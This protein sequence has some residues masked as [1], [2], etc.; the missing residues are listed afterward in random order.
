MGMKKYSFLYAVARS[1]PA[2]TSDGPTDHLRQA[3]EDRGDCVIG[4]FVD[5]GAE[6]RLRQRNVGWKNILSNLDGVDQVVVASARDLPGRTVRAGT[7][8]L[9]CW[10]A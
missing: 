2:D 7:N 6:V 4:T 9:A 1:S 10:Y 8:Q 3:V 5:Y